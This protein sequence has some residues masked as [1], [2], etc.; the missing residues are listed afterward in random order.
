[1][2]TFGDRQE[3]MEPAGLAGLGRDAATRLLPL[4]R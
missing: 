3:V 2:Q 1:M 4:N